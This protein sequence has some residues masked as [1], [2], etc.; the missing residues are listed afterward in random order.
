MTFICAES[1]RTFGPDDAAL[2]RQLGN[3]AALAI[4]NARLYREAQRVNRVKDE[5]LATLSHEL[6]TPL[7][8]ILGW[9]R[10]LRMGKLDDSAKRRAVETIE[11]NALSQAQ[12]I[13]DLLDVSRI[14]SGKFRVEVRPVD[15]PAVTEAAIDA[16]RLAAEAK[17]IALVPR[18]EHVPT[19]AGDATRLQQVVWNLLSNAIKFTPKGGRVEVHL[20]RVE[21]H[22]ELLVTD[23]GPG[24]RADFLPYVFDRF[25]QADG[26]STR[27]HSGLGLGLAI[28]RHLVEL[29]GGS[30]RAD[31]EGEGKGAA[32]SVRLPIASVRPK[33]GDDLHRDSIP[34]LDGP[35]PLGGLRVLVVDDETDA[36]ELVAAVLTEAGAR[37]TAVGSVREAL[38]IVEQTRPDVLVS[39]IGMPAEDG[40]TL[41]RRIRA[42]EKAVGRIPAAALTAYATLQ[43]RTRALSAGYSTHLPKPIEPAE[44]TAV[45]ASLAGRGRT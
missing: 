15:M 9:A 44:L 40:Y 14:I 34:E 16:V 6:R 20:L 30:V 37:V 3:S 8:A 33:L 23:D 10:L 1:G 25:R 42:M 43:D 36:R 31:S 7:N 38:E 45:V 12:L 26:T 22:V 35:L 4:D 11:R 18:I 5:F 28:V 27:A 2:A 19:L 29:H 32:F 41:I 13:E 17:A 24:I 21:S 39:D